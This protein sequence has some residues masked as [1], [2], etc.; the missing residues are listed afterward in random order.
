MIKAVIFDVGGVL[1]D[2]GTCG[3]DEL[4]RQLNLTPE[5]TR[6]IWADQIVRMGAGEL[7]EPAFWAELKS[8]Y[9]IRQVEPGEDLI[10]R[11][12]AG[13][14]KQNR[15]VINIAKQISLAGLDI[16]ILS[17]TIEPH[18]KVLREVGVYA[19]FR[20]VFLSYE[21]GIRK[22]DPR[23]YKR[24]LSKLQVSPEEAVFIDDNPEN[25]VAAENLG[26][27]GIIFKTTNQ[28]VAELAALLP[29]IDLESK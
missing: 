4:E 23:F 8:K 19:P 16:A 17:D 1:V 26:I 28:F 25:V 22:P 7:D 21:L 6:E 2:V 18:A 10:G 3:S 20:K 5:Q 11:S 12:F 15:R 24:V 14:L 27:H 13:V 9:G 29:G